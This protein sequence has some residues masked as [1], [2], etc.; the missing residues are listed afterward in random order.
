MMALVS[1]ER[2]LPRPAALVL[3]L[4]VVGAGLVASGPPWRSDDATRAAP[5][6][7]SRLDEAAAA[8]LLAVPLGCTPD[9]PTTLDLV[10]DAPDL[11][12][13]GARSVVAAHCE[14]GAGNPPSG[15]YVIDHSDA[16]SV[17]AVAVRP[18]QQLVVTGLAVVGDRVT[19]QADGWSRPD[20][21]RCC[22]D[23]HVV[24][25]LVAVGGKLVRASGS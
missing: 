18:Q 22:P 4:A 14:S 16:L 7:S 5:A 10:R 13:P 24:R 17:A 19:V 11:L 3:M 23:R 8:A 6:P 9:A 25:R 15:V 1:P 12:A 20:V 21:P 2:T